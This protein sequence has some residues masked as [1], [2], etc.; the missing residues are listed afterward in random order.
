M[1]KFLAGL[2][3]DGKIV[4]NKNSGNGIQVDVAVPSWGWRD[5]TSDIIVKGS[6]SND[7][8]WSIYT[9]TNFSAYQFS[10]NTMNQAWV[11][12]HIPHDYVPGTA[13]H[14]HAHWSNAAATPN[15]G[16][17][18]WAFEYSYAKGHQQEA[19]PA[20]NTVTAT[21][22]S[23][24]TRYFHQIAETAEL[25]IAGLE[26]DGM[27]LVRVYRDAAAAGDT[28]TDPVFLHHCDVHYQSTNMATK[29]KEPNFYT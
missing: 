23:N 7:P 17:E 22:A 14:I 26:P 28:C 13:I 29:Q 16:D 8:T 25:S 12:F 1:L 21:Q 6:G 20:S 19:F 27:L 2:I 4:L 10:P 18:V 24:A 3:I 9:G 15:T 11:A 5:I